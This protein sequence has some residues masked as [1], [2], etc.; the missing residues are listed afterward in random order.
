MK[1]I[2]IYSLQLD[3]VNTLLHYSAS[4][5]VVDNLGQSLL[6]HAARYI[7]KIPLFFS[8]KNCFSLLCK[9]LQM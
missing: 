2:L 1:F 6:H 4:T 9:D 8:L 5:Q 3:A 7:F